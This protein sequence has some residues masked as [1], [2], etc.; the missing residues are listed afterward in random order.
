MQL[1]KE[2]VH[3][4]AP[5]M[6]LAGFISCFWFCCIPPSF[7]AICGSTIKPEMLAVKNALAVNLN[8][9]RIAAVL[10]TCF[11]MLKLKELKF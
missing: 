3:R 2:K 11:L 1:K 5:V 8:D 9:Q 4:R 7:V 10:P 6:L